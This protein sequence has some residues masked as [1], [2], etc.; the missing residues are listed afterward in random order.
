MQFEAV[1]TRRSAALLVTK[2]PTLTARH[3]TR[4]TWK[5]YR[6][7]IVCLNLT[8]IRL[9]TKQKKTLKVRPA[10]DSLFQVVNKFLM[11]FGYF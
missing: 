3:E 6:T 9:Q 11:K 4:Q 8:V 2:S 10:V 5:E 7:R 1:I